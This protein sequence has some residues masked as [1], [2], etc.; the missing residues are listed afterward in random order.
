MPSSVQG[1]FT[2]ITADHTHNKQCHEDSL[3][4]IISPFTNK[5]S[6]TGWLSD[7]GF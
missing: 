5:D 6:K 7:F 1:T 3:R 2:P 4:T